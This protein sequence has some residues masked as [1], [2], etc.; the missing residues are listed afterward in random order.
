MKNFRLKLPFLLSPNGYLGLVLGLGLALFWAMSPPL[1]ASTSFSWVMLLVCALVIGHGAANIFLKDVD[2]SGIYEAKNRDEILSS[3]NGINYISLFLFLIIARLWCA[4]VPP[5]GPVLFVVLVL[6]LFLAICGVL[7]A[8]IRTAL[9][10]GDLLPPRLMA[11]GFLF[12]MVGSGLRYTIADAFGEERIGSFFEKREYTTAYYV[13][14]FPTQ[15]AAKNY[16]LPADIHVHYEQLGG[17]EPTPEKRCI[18]VERIHFPNG[19]VVRFADDGD[20]EPAA[21]GEKTALTDYH[22]KEWYVELVDEKVN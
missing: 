12:F 16:R 10:T 19:G 15:N 9:T 8:E 11:F 7:L 5:A 22:G 18:H 21:F 20:T 3:D 4:T 17:D 1:R 2:Y 13:N 6:P 14:V